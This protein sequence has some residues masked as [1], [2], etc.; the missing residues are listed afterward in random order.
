MNRL[1]ALPNIKFVFLKGLRLNSSI[2]WSWQQ[3]AGSL[4]KSGRLDAVRGTKKATAE[5]AFW[6]LGVAVLL[7]YF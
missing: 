3:K 4:G 1:W 5:V 7:L 2:Y 6:I